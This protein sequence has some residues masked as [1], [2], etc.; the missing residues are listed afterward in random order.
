MS[1]YLLSSLHLYRSFP[2]HVLSILRTGKFRQMLLQSLFI[3]KIYWEGL[4][5]RK[6][7]EDILDVMDRRG[8][9]LVKYLNDKKGRQRT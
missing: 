1:V 5:G 6:A 8:K 2:E 3:D 9:M 7:I 4:G